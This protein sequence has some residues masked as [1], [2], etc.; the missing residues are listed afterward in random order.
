MTHKTQWQSL[1]SDDKNDGNDPNKMIVI[2][3][4]F[5]ELILDARCVNICWINNNTLIRTF[6]RHLYEYILE[7]VMRTIVLK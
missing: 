5:D 7:W 3:N 1:F 4:A 2:E 6:W